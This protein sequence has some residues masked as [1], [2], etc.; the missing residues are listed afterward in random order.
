MKINPADLIAEDSQLFDVLERVTSDDQN[1][2]E[3]ICIDF[4]YPFTGIVYNAE[5]EEESR[6][7]LGAD[8]DFYLF[9]QNVE[10]DQFINVSF[11]ISATL[12]DGG[13]FQINT[14]EELFDLISGCLVQLQQETI[15]F[16]ESVVIECVW[17]VQLPEGADF[18]TYENAVFDV[19]EDLTVT[20]YHRG[21]SYQ[22]TWIFY[23][24]E[25]LLHLNI[26]I[27]DPDAVGEDWNFDW[28]VAT[29]QEFEMSI[30][31]D[32]MDFD[33]IKE[34]DEE[35]YCTTLEFKECGSSENPDEAEFILEDYEACIEVIAAP[36]NMPETFGYSFFPSEEDATNNTN[37]INASVP[38]NNTEN[39]QELYV[40]IQDLN[41]GEF[42]LATITLIAEDCTD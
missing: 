11:P 37:M 33:L 30:F 2:D 7:T 25:N 6:Q 3:V 17:K 5:G 8:V 14:K 20:F 24:I 27:N 32:D 39:P 9:L 26:N 16:G 13:N 40:R 38:Y 18:N 19:N 31:N 21:E 42:E 35:N 23:Y 4:V 12:F 1:L 36:Q 28:R 41:T 29:L 22:G 15:G 10:E 34:C